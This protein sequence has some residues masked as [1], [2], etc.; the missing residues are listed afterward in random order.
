[1]KTGRAQYQC[2]PAHRFRALFRPDR[3]SRR[4]GAQM[5]EQDRIAELQADLATAPPPGPIVQSVRI[6][7]RAIYLATLL[8]AVVWL[9]SNIRQI[10]PDSQAVV[11]RFGRIVRTQSAGLLIA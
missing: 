7:F 2:G 6:G 4:R 8:L 3:R 11:Q 5:S 1:G 10:S 9:F